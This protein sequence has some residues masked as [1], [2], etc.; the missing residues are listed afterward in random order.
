[1]IEAV[2]YA[3]GVGLSLNAHLIIHWAGTDAADDPDGRLFSKVR[4]G[5][6]RWLRQRRVAFAGIWCREKLS[7]GQAEVEHCHLIFH[8]PAR[9]LVG[10][11]I[12]GTGTN[13]MLRGGVEL[14]QVEALLYRLVARYAGRPEDY[15]VKLKVPTDGVDLPGPYNGR[16]YDGLYLIKGVWSEGLEAIP[17]HQEGLAQASRHHLR[18]ALRRHPEHRPSG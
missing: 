18:Q 6:A 11:K 1:M 2:Q 15:A 10:A 13:A 4:E 8:L 16:S 5:F 7:G 12:V 17:A 9:W 14:L 3:E